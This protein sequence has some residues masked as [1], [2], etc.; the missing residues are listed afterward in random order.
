MRGDERFGT[1]V[2]LRGTLG[3]AYFSCGGFTRDVG[4]FRPALRRS[5][6]ELV[7]RVVGMRTS[8]DECCSTHGG[9]SRRI[10]GLLGKDVRG[11]YLPCV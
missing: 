9:T 8:S 5:L 11:R 1:T 2:R 6:F 7:Q 4:C 10:T 3:G